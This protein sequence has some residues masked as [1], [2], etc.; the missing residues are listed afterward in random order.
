MMRCSESLSGL[1]LLFVSP[2]LGLLLALPVRDPASWRRLEG[3]EF[4]SL[5]LK[6]CSYRGL[7]SSF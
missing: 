7:G 1:N 3:K 2:P 5:S 4:E 6:S